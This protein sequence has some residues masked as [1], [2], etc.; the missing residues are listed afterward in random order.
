V[1]PENGG[2]GDDDIPKKD[3]RKRV[4]ELRKRVSDFEHLEKTW[5]TIPKGTGDLLFLVNADGT[6]IDYSSGRD[7]DLYVSPEKFLNRK[8][9][10]VLPEEVGRDI[11]EA[12]EK[13]LQDDEIVTI[14]YRLQLKDG[15]QDFEGRFVPFKEGQVFVVVRNITIQKTAIRALR[16]SE[17]RF[18]TVFEEGAIGMTIV[19]KE[20]SYLKVNK[21]YCRMLGYSEEE[22][23]TMKVVDVTHPDDIEQDRKHLKKMAK[24]EGDRFTV[25]KRFIKKNKE[26]L[27]GELSVSSV[28]DE[29]GDLLYFIS[30]VQDITER[31]R[32]EEEVKWRLMRFR[33][34]ERKLYIVKETTPTLC[35]EAFK[36][37]LKA[38]YHG[39]IISR[40]PEKEFKDGVEDDFQF[41]WL[42]VKKKKAL[43][44]ELK[45]IEARIEELPKKSVVLV[46]RLEFMVNRY[47][48][49]RTLSLI[50]FLRDHTHLSGII[51]IVSIDPSTLD[52]HQVRLLEKEGAEIE[53]MPSIKLHEDLL[54]VLKIVYERNILGSKPS[55][56]DIEK[57]LKISKPTVR[58]RIE[59]L[60]HLGYIVVD[61]KGRRKVLS[62][63]Q[64]GRDLFKM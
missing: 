49:K 33:L 28:R 17:D 30:M 34:D 31:K 20:L 47:G 38:G 52:K 4:E 5:R 12:I 56:K 23:M 61:K 1:D 14:E 3:L 54:E 51:G 27:W 53:A 10:S 8:V 11:V 41:L 35:M 55:Y 64:R 63:T 26:I 59:G 40:T 22:L 50:H 7:D 15:T 46:D 42:H 21:E 36:D 45:D 44:Q 37:L 24:G 2:M 9:Q 43:A 48:F 29:D 6:I 60:Q 62:L 13:T 18:R 58:K 25:E 19:D 32:E 39:L 57:G 16:E